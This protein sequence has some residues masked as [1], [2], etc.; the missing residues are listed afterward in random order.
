MYSGWSLFLYLRLSSFPV[1]KTWPC[2]VTL[3]IR[4]CTV[5]VLFVLCTV[6][7]ETKQVFFVMTTYTWKNKSVES[8]YKYDIL[9]FSF[10]VW[11]NFG[12]FNPHH[13][14]AGG[15]FLSR[16]VYT[17]LVTR[18]LE[19]TILCIKISW[20]V[21]AGIWLKWLGFGIRDQGHS[22][23]KCGFQ[24]NIL[25]GSFISYFWK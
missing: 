15:I 17:K 23:S 21:K 16:L 9:A 11:L 2:T 14:K 3:Y 20:T 12:P 10:V 6:V 8:K 22:I 1:V 18:S 4:K 25:S 24:S 19:R 5:N 7:W 13:E